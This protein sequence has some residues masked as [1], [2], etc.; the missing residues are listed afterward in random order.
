MNYMIQFVITLLVL[1]LI[2]C[3]VLWV[4]GIAGNSEEYTVMSLRTFCRLLKQ[5]R[6]FDIDMLTGIGYFNDHQYHEWVMPRWTWYP[7]FALALIYTALHKET[8]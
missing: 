1:I 4:I 5:N 2:Y 6:V 3:F 7:I 8:I